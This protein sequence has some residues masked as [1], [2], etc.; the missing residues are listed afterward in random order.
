MPAFSGEVIG[1]GL[2]RQIRS[3]RLQEF[4]QNP[5]E[6]GFGVNKH[7]VTIK[8]DESRTLK[9]CLH[10]GGLQSVSMVEAV[11]YSTCPTGTTIGPSKS[12]NTQSSPWVGLTN[13]RLPDCCSPHMSTLESARKFCLFTASGN[14]RMHLS[15]RVDYSD[16]FSCSLA[17]PVLSNRG[18]WV[19]HFFS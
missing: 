15:N 12:Y 4:V 16:G 14:H 17:M 1:A 6:Y 3:N 19:K 18:L 11:G 10:W 7:A 8:N 13:V 9:R 2:K 5:I